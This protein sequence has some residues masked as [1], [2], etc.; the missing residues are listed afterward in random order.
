M[1]R[2]L[3]ALCE[4]RTGATQR[5]TEGEV[6]AATSP[7]RVG[8]SAQDAR[9]VERR[10]DRGGDKGGA[11]EAGAEPPEK[12]GADTELQISGDSAPAA[13]PRLPIACEGSRRRWLTS[14]RTSRSPEDDSERG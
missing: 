2:L 10:R 4:M 5:V 8:V 14:P 7:S 6:A 11:E 12:R 1:G 3:H 9:G 13:G